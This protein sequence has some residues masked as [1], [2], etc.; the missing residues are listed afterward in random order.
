[1][2]SYPAVHS[3]VISPYKFIWDVLHYIWS[4]KDHLSTCVNKLPRNCMTQEE[5]DRIKDEQLE[6]SLYFVEEKVPG[7][8]S[9]KCPVMK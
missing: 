5:L 8:D 3:I 1:M 7:W 6:A 4:S 9:D 2:L